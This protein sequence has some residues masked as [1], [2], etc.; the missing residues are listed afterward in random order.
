MERFPH[1]LKFALAV[2]ALAVA[3]VSYFVIS[4]PPIQESND[5]L[6]KKETEIRPLTEPRQWARI[7][8][9]ESDG[10]ST[11]V[12]SGLAEQQLKKFSELLLSEDQADLKK[13]ETMIAAA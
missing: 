6:T 1:V 5:S 3:V 13:I 4:T 7:D 11:E 12:F 9:A 2:V 8:N 10:W